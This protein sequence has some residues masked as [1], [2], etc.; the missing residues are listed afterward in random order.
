MRVPYALS[1][2]GEEEIEAVVKVLRTSTLP[3]DNVQEFEEKIARLFGKTRGVMVN[4]GSSAL[5]LGI[6]AMNLPKGSEV[7]TPALPSPPRLR[8][9]SRTAWCPSFVDVDPHTL[10]IRIDKIEEMITLNTKAM[11]IPNLMGNIPDWDAL[12]AIADKYMS[13]C[14]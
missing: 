9:R 13:Q 12:R 4:S 10:N 5:L 6:A 8:L 14:A 2:S 1:V 3:G 7:I 11:V